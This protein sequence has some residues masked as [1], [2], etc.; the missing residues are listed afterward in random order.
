MRHDSR[1]RLMVFLFSDLVGSV[2]LKTRYGDE[3]A[4]RVI[5]RHDVFNRAVVCCE[6]LVQTNAR[7]AGYAE[8]N[9]HAVGF[10]H[11]YEESR[12]IHA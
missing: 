3:A 12:S 11:L 10:K 6:R 7:F 8:D 9:L 5:A 4:A 2:A 1:S